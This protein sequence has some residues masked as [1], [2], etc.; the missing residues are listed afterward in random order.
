MTVSGRGLARTYG[1]KPLTWFLAECTATVQGRMNP[2]NDTPHCDVTEAKA[3]RLSTH[4]TF[5]TRFKV[6]TGIV[7]DGYC[8]S[9]GH[10]TCVISV[11]NA[12]GQGTV[13]HITFHD[14]CRL[15]AQL[16][17]D[18][19]RRHRDRTPSPPLPPLLPLLR[20]RP[21]PRP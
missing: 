7:G 1:G 20:R 9:D 8:G 4:G 6:E 14:A 19:G 2:S 17:L 18:D 21:P 5:S 11:G 13:V 16:H 12:R 3:I 10:D 15:D